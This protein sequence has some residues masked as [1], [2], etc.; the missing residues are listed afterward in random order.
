MAPRGRF[1]FPF[2][3][4]SPSEQ[5]EGM[6]SPE[7]SAK[8]LP[9]KNPECPSDYAAFEPSV[10]SPPAKLLRRKERKGRGFLGSF[11]PGLPTSAMSALDKNSRGGTVLSIMGSATVRAPHT[12][13]FV[14]RRRWR[15]KLA[16]RRRLQRSCGPLHRLRRGSVNG[17][18][19]D[20]RA[21]G[22]E[23]ISW[24]ERSPVRWSWQFVL[25]GAE[26]QRARR[27]MLG[28]DVELYWPAFRPM[29]RSSRRDSVRP[30][31]CR[32]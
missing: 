13:H 29:R 1:V 6:D 8:S 5:S 14:L 2:P 28:R 4:L 21:G 17:R 7:G 19:R 10:P 3:I 26:P 12:W 11:P 20:R 27:R 25:G 31:V 15:R 22:E 32:P 23:R 18:P 24:S 9:V 30:S 16:T